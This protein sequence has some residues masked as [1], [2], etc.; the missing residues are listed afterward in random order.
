MLLLATASVSRAWP[1]DKRKPLCR[2]RLT[3][4]AV[5]MVLLSASFSPIHESLQS[6]PAI[7]A[8]GV[9]QKLQSGLGFDEVEA[10]HQ[11]HHP[12]IPGEKRDPMINMHLDTFF[13]VA[14]SSV[15]V[16]SDELYL[17]LL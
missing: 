9:G 11:P 6:F 8:T 1:Y 15:V 13:N 3:K 12:L 10:V 16:G 2:H 5:S 7:C 17:R 4:P 14:S